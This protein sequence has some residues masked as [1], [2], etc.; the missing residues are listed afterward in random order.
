[1]KGQG[2]KEPSDY[3]H[4]IYCESPKFILHKILDFLLRF[5]CFV[6]VSPLLFSYRS[7]VFW[8]CAGF[9]WDSDTCLTISHSEKYSKLTTQTRSVS[10]CT[11]SLTCTRGTA[12]FLRMKRHSIRLFS[13]LF[14]NVLPNIKY[15]VQSKTGRSVGWLVY[16][17]C[18]HL[19]HRATVKFFVSL[20][21]LNLRYSVG[22]L[23]RV[24]SPSQR[25]YLTQT[26]NKH[27]HPCL[28]WDSNPWSQRSS[29]RRQF[30]P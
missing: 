18:S 4:R 15:E 14:K 26:Q 30:M 8:N 13:L 29:K 22:P 19:E 11:Y 12:W 27:G 24:I 10:C 6:S 3:I 21:F 1:M 2:C 7:T 20:Q 16:S 25:R 9:P 23:G 17:C 5:F 28:E